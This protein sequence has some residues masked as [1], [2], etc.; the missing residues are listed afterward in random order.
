MPRPEPDVDPREAF[1]RRMGAMPD[2]TLLRQPQ[3]MNAM[4][5]M[6]AMSGQ[7]GG[8]G[9]MGATPDAFGGLLTEGDIGQGGQPLVEYEHEGA[10]EPPSWWERMRTGTTDVGVP[11]TPDL[12]METIIDFLKKM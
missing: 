1:F 10:E 7:M 2:Q 12:D 3:A 5:A 9:I 6:N 4:N 8:Q 11:R